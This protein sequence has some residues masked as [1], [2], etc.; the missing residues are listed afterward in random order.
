MMK[1]VTSVV[2]LLICL[3]ILVASIV[4]QQSATVN[5]TGGS[6]VIDQTENLVSTAN[7]TFY[8]EHA[9]NGIDFTPRT[10]I[11]LVSKSDGRQG[12]LFLDRNTISG[13]E[14]KKLKTLITNNGLYTIRIRSEKEE[15][16]SEFVLSS[17][18]ICDLQ[19]SAFKEDILVYLNGN[20]GIIGLSY[21]NP[22]MTIAHECD[23]SKLKD[24]VTFQ[25]RIKLGEEVTGQLVPLT[26]QASRPPYL[27]NVRLGLEEEKQ[28]AQN[29]QQ[30]SFFSKYWYVI[31]GI[32]LFSL[33]SG[34]GQDSNA[35]KAGEGGQAGAAPAA[36]PQQ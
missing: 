20:G 27:Q 21:S 32:M 4:A 35:G 8:I 10:K 5:P 36:A 34:G 26:V 2:M 31:V 1:S 3:L 17:V 14:V 16:T 18:P 11:Q 24:T 19:R 30:Q 13:E 12:L 23:P 9:F 22:K 25:T 28:P 29:K 7:I 15:F 33:L 6:T